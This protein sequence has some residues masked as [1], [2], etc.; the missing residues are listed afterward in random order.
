MSTKVPFGLRLCVASIHCVLHT[1]CITQVLLRLCFVCRLGIKAASEGGN[2]QHDTATP[3]RCTSEAVQVDDQHGDQAA[4]GAEQAHLDNTATPASATTLPAHLSTEGVWLQV[5]S[6]L[7]TGI[8][9]AGT[10]DAVTSTH[11]KD[12]G[13]T[14]TTPMLQRGNSSTRLMT[15]EQALQVTLQ[16]LLVTS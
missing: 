15:P 13:F 8:A 5:T 9:A 11:T 7:G 1:L 2:I 14:T 10:A 3:A 6:R 16:L 4:H 12:S